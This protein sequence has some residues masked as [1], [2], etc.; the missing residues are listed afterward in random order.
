MRRGHPLDKASGAALVW[1]Q[2]MNCHQSV[3]S[4]LAILLMLGLVLPS[5]GGTGNPG[6]DMQPG[7]CGCQQHRCCVEAPADL[8]AKAPEGLPPEASRRMAPDLFLQLSLLVTLQAQSPD[9]PTLPPACR[10][11]RNPDGVP[12]HLRFRS[13]R[14]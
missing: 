14:I 6:V 10:E 3:K 9:S 2:A 5:P 13:L 7:N 8:P 1:T 4:L 12:L 11:M